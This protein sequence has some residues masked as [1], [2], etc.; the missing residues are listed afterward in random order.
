VL[1]AP[2]SPVGGTYAILVA[3]ADGSESWGEG[4][5]EKQPIVI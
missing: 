2:P 3:P 1:C 5:L 4:V